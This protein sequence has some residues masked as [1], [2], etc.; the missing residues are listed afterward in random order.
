LP[1]A[2]TKAACS[3]SGGG[4]GALLDGF[5]LHEAQA[6]AP[7]VSQAKKPEVLPVVLI[8]TPAPARL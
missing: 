7:T 5:W 6:T 3:A 1:K 2:A 8:A 4:A